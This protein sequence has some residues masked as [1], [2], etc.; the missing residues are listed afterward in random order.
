MEG[1]DRILLLCRKNN[2]KIFLCHAGVVREKRRCQIGSAEKN[3]VC[4]KHLRKKKKG[5]MVYMAVSKQLI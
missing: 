5:D 2:D 4:S 3:G 1:R